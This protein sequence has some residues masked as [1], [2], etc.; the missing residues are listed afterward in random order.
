MKKSGGG[1]VSDVL[2]QRTLQVRTDSEQKRNPKTPIAGMTNSVLGPSR[3][4]RRRR[5]IGR[6]LQIVGVST[7]ITGDQQNIHQVGK[8]TCVLGTENLALIGHSLSVS[9][10]LLSGHLK[11][12]PENLAWN[13]RLPKSE[14]PIIVSSSVSLCYLYESKVQLHHHSASLT[15]NSLI[16]PFPC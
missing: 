10:S 5:S 12:C 16:S 14:G 1:S 9:L 3:R 8:E 7:S 6:W 4:G 15:K 11:K 13:G 2:L